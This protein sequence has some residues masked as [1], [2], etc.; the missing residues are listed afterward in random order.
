MQNVFYKFNERFYDVETEKL[1][2]KVPINDVFFRLHYTDY[3]LSC[4]PILFFPNPNL[5]WERNTLTTS[6][7]MF[8]ET[9]TMYGRSVA[10]WR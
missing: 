4:N 6:H 10:G 5:A 1:V 7:E 8:C 9:P 2:L 3:Y